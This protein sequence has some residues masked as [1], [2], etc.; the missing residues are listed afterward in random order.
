MVRVKQKNGAEVGAGKAAVGS[1]LGG[2]LLRDESDEPEEFVA[3]RDPGNSQYGHEAEGEGTALSEVQAKLEEKEIESRENYEK[4]VRTLAEFDNARKRL[5]QEKEDAIE[6]A[7]ANL[8]LSI[9]PIMDN[10]ELALQHAESNRNFDTLYSG[11]KQILKQMKETLQKQ[12]VEPIEALG[13][14]FDPEVH[15]AIGHADSDEYEEGSV[16]QE[17]RTGYRMKNRTLRPSMV[18][19]AGG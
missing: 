11:L 13:K 5:R 4:Y 7:N 8:A 18:R 16:A 3:D 1:T 2:E 19:V 17:L 14:P 10:F 15:E 12:G 9:L 6:Y